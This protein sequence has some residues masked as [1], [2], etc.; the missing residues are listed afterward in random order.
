MG[1]YFD[2]LG[3]DYSNF[4]QIMAIISYF[5][6]AF[7]FYKLAEK[8]KVKNSWL[9][10]IPFLQFIIFFHIIDK[11]ALNILLYFLAIIPLIGAI[12][13]IV[14]NII[15]K[16]DFYKRFKTDT[17]FIVLCIIIPFFEWVYLIYMALSANVRYQGENRFGENAF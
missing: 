4:I 5:F 10:F 15:W 8:A 2:L 11:S 12:I 14:L 13:L 16:V 1:N 6:Q 9:S 3:N 7:S 17:I